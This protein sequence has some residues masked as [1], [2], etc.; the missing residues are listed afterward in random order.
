MASW[1]RTGCLS[2][3]ALG[4]LTLPAVAQEPDG[5]IVYARVANWQI[6]RPNWE[7]YEANAKKNEVPVLDKLLADG[8]ITEYA[9]ARNTVHTP[10]GYTHV[11]WFASKTLAGLESAL[12]ALVAAQG[13]LPAAEQRRGNTDFAGSKHSDTVA[14][15]R[16]IKGKGT[17]LTSGY[18]YVSMDVIQPGKVAAYNERL[19]KQV[20]P[21]LDSLFA[22][23][24]VTSFGIDQE[25]VHTT[26]PGTRTRWVIVPDAAGLDKMLAAGA[27]ANQART[28]AERQANAE[29]S[30]EILVGSAHR[31]ELWEILA[32]AAK[33]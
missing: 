8:V 19:E 11:T 32:Y 10:D 12:A 23:G 17:K 33:Y 22:S 25:F 28:P 16:V 26:D 31:D 2:L 1:L 29:A 20:R 4:S 3:V 18:A 21:P 27:A 7:A 13:K 24:A 14:R 30:R 5:T 9:V 15:S 6:A